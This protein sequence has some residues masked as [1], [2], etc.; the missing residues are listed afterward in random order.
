ME[1]NATPKRNIASLLDRRFFFGLIAGLILAT[2]GLGAVAATGVADSTIDADDYGELESI[3]PGA[4]SITDTE[5][6]E[7]VLDAYPGTSVE[8]VDVDT[9]DDGTLVYDV[10]LDSGEE[11]M[12]D[13]RTGEILGAEVDDAD[14]DGDD[15]Q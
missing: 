3:A 12:V 7:A 2:A 1:T 10:S 4:I 11:I 5:A 8:E 15:D 14:E 13:A 9:Q 6:R